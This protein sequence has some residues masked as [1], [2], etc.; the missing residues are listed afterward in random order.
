MSRIN[1][2]QTTTNSLRN[3]IS[4][5]NMSLHNKSQLNETTHDIFSVYKNKDSQSPLEKKKKKVVEESDEKQEL[6]TYLIQKRKLARKMKKMK[7]KKNPNVK[8][9]NQKTPGNNN[10][11]IK[12]RNEQ[13]RLKLKKINKESKKKLKKRFNIFNQVS[14]KNKPLLDM[15][16]NSKNLSENWKFFLTLKCEKIFPNDLLNINS[17]TENLQNYLDNIPFPVNE[18]KEDLIQET[19]TV[20]RFNGDVIKTEKAPQKA[21]D[22]VKNEDLSSSRKQEMIQK[23]K[24]FLQSLHIKESQYEESKKETEDFMLKINKEVEELKKRNLKESGKEAKEEIKEVPSEKISDELSKQ[25]QER[26]I[27]FNLK[28]FDKFSLYNIMKFWFD[29]REALKEK[30]KK[31]PNYKEATEKK[32]IEEKEKKRQQKASTVKYIYTTPSDEVRKIIP[33][34]SK[35]YTIQKKD[36]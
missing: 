2:K 34:C 16:K 5:L 33:F 22:N 21:L 23:R 36:V 15:F 12:T 3:Q 26:I 19:K 14:V 31:L 10:Q 30:M 29:N 8:K 17:L 27:N 25:I 32:E 18:D 24:E 9:T 20:R 11:L 7:Q 1:K 4:S 28:T 13:R 6:M 35:K